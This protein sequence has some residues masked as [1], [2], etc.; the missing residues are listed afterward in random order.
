MEE[1]QLERLRQVVK[2]E[3]DHLGIDVRGDGLSIGVHDAAAGISPECMFVIEV[4]KVLLHLIELV[5][6]RLEGVSP[7][8][9]FCELPLAGE[10]VQIEDCREQLVFV[11]AAVA[12][13]AGGKLL[14]RLAE[15]VAQAFEHGSRFA[16]RV[17]YGRRSGSCGC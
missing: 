14:G 3:H 2:E 6:E 15:N 7:D 16:L 5:V 9:L 1:G 11:V 8:G 13:M 12:A 4:S 10:L 17:C